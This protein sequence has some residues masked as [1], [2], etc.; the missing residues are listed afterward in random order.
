MTKSGVIEIDVGD[1]PELTHL[2]PLDQAVA[3]VIPDQHHHRGAHAHRRLKLLHI[4]QKARVAGDSDNLA[5]GH[6]QL[7]GDRTRARRSPCWQSRWK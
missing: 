6:C 3:A 7:G 2:L 5:L 1:A 4:H